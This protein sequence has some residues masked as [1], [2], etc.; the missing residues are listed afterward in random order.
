MQ[1]TPQSITLHHA[2]A[3]THYVKGED[4]DIGHTF[5][6]LGASALPSITAW[7]L[8]TPLALKVTS[9]LTPPSSAGV[10][11]RVRPN[12]PWGCRGQRNRVRLQDTITRDMGG[13]MDGCGGAH[14]NGETA[15]VHGEALTGGDL[16]H[17]D[18]GL[19]VLGGVVDEQRGRPGGPYPH[20]PEAH[21]GSLGELDQVQGRDLVLLVAARCRLRHLEIS[22]SLLDPNRGWFMAWSAPDAELCCCTEAR[23]DA[24]E[25]ETAVLFGHPITGDVRPRFIQ[26][27]KTA[28]PPSD[29]NQ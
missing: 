20:G 9:S 3:R 15:V 4:H 7:C 2:H 28:A 22:Q 16:L 8:S 10:H 27:E 25:F 17:R 29:I 11:V 14:L 18:L 19:H 21:E 24:I 6:F 23:G 1:V 13:W 12:E 26:W 5:F